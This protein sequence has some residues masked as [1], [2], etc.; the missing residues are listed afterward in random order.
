MVY[1]MTLFIFFEKNPLVGGC[2]EIENLIINPINSGNFCLKSFLISALKKGA[3]EVT[4][5]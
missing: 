3:T 1:G 2:A 5:T 4:L